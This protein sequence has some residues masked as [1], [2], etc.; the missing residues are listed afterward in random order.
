MDQSDNPRLVLNAPLLPSAGPGEDFQLPNRLRASATHGVHSK[1]KGQNQT[2]DS[3]ISTSSGRWPQNVA[4]K[5]HQ[6]PDPCVLLYAAIARLNRLVRRHSVTCGRDDR[7]VHD[8][9]DSLSSYNACHCRLYRKHGSELRRIGG[10]GQGV[11]VLL[12]KHALVCVPIVKVRFDSC[13]SAAAVAVRS[14]HFA[15]RRYRLARRRDAFL[16]RNQAERSCSARLNAE[17]RAHVIG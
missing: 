7:R 8:N 13:N 14:H 2:A 12:A 11:F 17:K 6:L 4:Y 9:P 1:L 15:D 10:T 16:S 5:G 3:Q